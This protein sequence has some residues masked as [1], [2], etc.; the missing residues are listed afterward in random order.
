[1]KKLLFT[2][3]LAISTFSFAQIDFNNTRFGVDAA[4]NRSGVSNAHNPSGPRYTFQAGAFA[5]IPIGTANQFFLQPEVLYYGAGETGKDSDYKGKDG[6]NAVYANN[7]ISVPVYFK[8]YFSESPSEF[9][10]MAGPRFNFLV[11][12][13]VKNVPDSKPYYDPD[14]PL[15]DLNGKAASF[16]FGIG[17]GFGYSL[18][19]EWEFTIKYDLGLSNTYKGLV[20]ELSSKSKSEQVASIGVSYIF[21]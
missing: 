4:F 16:N 1:M 10:A 13:N 6:Y 2:S 14:K 17:L 11:N 18:N 8:A 9:F 5:L 20:N 7:Y 12:Q 3:A 15:G 19:R 21:K